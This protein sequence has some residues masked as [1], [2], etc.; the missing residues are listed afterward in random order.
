LKKKPNRRGFLRLAAVA[1]VGV[2]AAR[3]IGRAESRREETDPRE[4]AAQPDPLTLFLCGDVMTGRGLDQIMPHPS[5]PQ[6]FE[7]YVTSALDYVRL[8]ERINGPIRRPVDFNYVWGDALAEWRARRPD[9]RIVNLETSVTTSDNHEPKGINYRMNPANIACLLAGDIDCCLL[10]N[11]H[12]L[13]WGQRG[14]L[15]TLDTLERSGLRHAGAGRD[16]EA[17]SAPAILS[18]P[19]NRRMLVYAFASESSGVPRNWAATDKRA[20]VNLLPD[21]SQSSV[22]WIADSVRSEKQPG[23]VAIASIHWGSNWGYAIPR[24]HTAF[25]R[26]L[27]DEAA[28]DV[29][30]GH[31]SH[32]PRPIEVYRG[33]LILYGCG[34][35]LNDY[36]GIKGYEQFRDD[37]VLMY[38]LRVHPGTGELMDL[39]MT[40]MQIRNF[41]LNHA[42]DTDAGWIAGILDEFSRPF[43]TSVRLTADNRLQVSWA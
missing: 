13:D 7:P 19:G 40:P 12:V 17:S 16:R 39:E 42:N 28:I 21:L 14:L 29:V 8:A 3:S 9:I 20:G 32:H 5:P 2:V 4:P 35:F 10:A 6:L 31:S 43:G 36:E 15:E 25:A 11:N 18:A 23:D 30:Y 22:D 1:T 27:I 33:K 34:D 41:R 37:L 24:E 38:F 26:R